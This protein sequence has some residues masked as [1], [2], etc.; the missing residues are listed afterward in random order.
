MVPAELLI[1]C[2]EAASR[3]PAGWRGLA[4]LH[5]TEDGEDFDRLSRLT[6]GRRDARLLELRR[7][8]FGDAMEGLATCPA[9]GLVLDVGLRPSDLALAPAADVPMSVERDGWAVEFR[10]PDTRDLHAAAACPDVES[11]RHV[12]IER[13]VVRATHGSVEVSPSGIPSEVIADMEE[14]MAN[15]DPQADLRFPLTCPD[16]AVSWEAGIDLEHFVGA[17]VATGARRLM[18]DVHRLAAAYGW[19]EAEILGLSTVRR[20]AYLD[21]VAGE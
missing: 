2:W 4:L 6:L 14:A 13:C 9:C 12:L 20:E 11:A 19:T 5:P 8:L 18:R 3:A 1:D 10:L 15:A 17:E 7:A 21:L 16:C